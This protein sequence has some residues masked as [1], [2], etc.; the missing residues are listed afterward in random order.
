MTGYPSIPPPAHPA[1]PLTV[2]ARL[3][4]AHAAVA[5][6]PHLTAPPAVAVPG[7]ARYGPHR[8]AV[9]GRA[10]LGDVEVDLGGGV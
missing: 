2:A 8:H 4:V 3:V 9:Q 10:G 1:L 5:V 7:V 6:Q